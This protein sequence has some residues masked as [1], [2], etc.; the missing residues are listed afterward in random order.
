MAK[1]YPFETFPTM[2]SKKNNNEILDE[3]EIKAR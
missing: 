2:P 3:T 1:Q